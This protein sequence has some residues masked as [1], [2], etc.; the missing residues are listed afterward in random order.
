MRA[1]VARPGRTISRPG[2]HCAIL[3]A[4]FQGVAWK[5]DI[6][7][8]RVAAAA[9]ALLLLSISRAEPP[10]NFHSNM[11][12]GESTTTGASCVLLRSV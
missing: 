6:S 10:V 12:D 4:P 5:L 7:P 9:V 8:G 1:T 11:A 2:Q 3:V